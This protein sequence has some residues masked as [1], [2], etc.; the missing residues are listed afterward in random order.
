MITRDQ[1]KAEIENVPEEHLVMLY[2]IVK[3]F[4]EP[5]PDFETRD[6]DDAR[7]RALV[8]EAYG[9]TADA[10]LERG[11]QGSFEVREPLE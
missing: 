10:P 11:A 4:E 8:A 9:S 2:K 3:A 1:L 6:L 5:A 7:W